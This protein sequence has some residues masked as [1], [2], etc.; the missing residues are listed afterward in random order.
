MALTAV[1]MVMMLALTLL[2]LPTLVVRQLLFFV[3]IPCIRPGALDLIL[4]RFRCSMVSSLRSLWRVIWH[5]IF[6]FRRVGFKWLL[7][8]RGGWCGG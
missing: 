8:W 6:R 1:V 7:L 4:R 2:L 3:I 5:L